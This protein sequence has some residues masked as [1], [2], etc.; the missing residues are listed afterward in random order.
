[1]WSETFK[2]PPSDPRLLKLTINEAL[3]QVLA[4]QAL[5]LRRREAKERALRGLGGKWDQMPPQA[6]VRRDA[7]AAKLADTP[8]LTGDPEWDAIELAETAP[9]RVPHNM[10]V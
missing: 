3:E 2:I 5:E 9:D 10:K 8:H 4:I 1:M 6:E 7:D